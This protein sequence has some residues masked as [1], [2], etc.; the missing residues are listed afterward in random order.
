MLQNGLFVQ[1]GSAKSSQGQGMFN[2][3]SFHMR[4]FFFVV[5]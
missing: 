2:N 5:T 3:H 1:V 4:T